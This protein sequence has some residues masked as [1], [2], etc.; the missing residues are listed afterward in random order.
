MVLKNPQTTKTT[1]H[2]EKKKR[3]QM[4]YYIFS[5]FVSMYFSGK[6]LSEKII[7]LL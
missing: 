1:K 5:I 6:K 7:K 3:R 2:K 4:E